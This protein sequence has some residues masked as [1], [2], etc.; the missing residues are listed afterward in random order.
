MIDFPEFMKTEANR[1]PSHSQSDGVHGW[2][3]HGANGYQ[4]AYWICET[5]GTAQEH[6]HQFDEYVVVVQGSYT[7]TLDGRRIDL[8]SGDEYLVPRHTP[9]AGA[10][11]AGTRTI[12][13]FGGRRIPQSESTLK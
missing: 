8:R 5:D 12:H 13:C 4:M 10:F 7:L 11:T 3:Y 6:V 1:I 9:H 2:V